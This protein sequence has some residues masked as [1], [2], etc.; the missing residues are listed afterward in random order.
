MADTGKGRFDGKVALISGGAEGIGGQA[1]RQF[2][3]DGGSV[4]IGDIQADKLAAH[5]DDLGERAVGIALDVRDLSAWEQAV[6]QARSAFG[7]LTHVFNVAGISEPGSVEDVPLDSWERT[8]DINLNGTFNGCRAGLTAIVEADEPGAIVNVGSMLALRPGAGFAAYCASK[9]G[10][11]A[12]SKTLALHCAENDYK[13]RVNT[14]HPGAIN[15]PMYHRYLEAYPGPR[16][17]AEALFTANHPMKRVGEPEEVVEA[18]CWLAS[19]AAS[20]TTGCDINVDGGGNF[21]A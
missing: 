20:F 12:L 6:E 10:V 4:V 21:R 1:A 18:I 7:K 15:T 3:A 19:D 2:V 11:T 8:I 9:S 13:V 14:V 5:A 16:D 17:E